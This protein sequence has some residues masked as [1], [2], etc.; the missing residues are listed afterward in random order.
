MTDIINEGHIGVFML[1]AVGIMFMIYIQNYVIYKNIYLLQPDSLLQWIRFA[2]SWVHR[3]PSLRI[4][5]FQ[6]G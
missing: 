4:C 3:K 5:Q 1:K 2:R 6:R